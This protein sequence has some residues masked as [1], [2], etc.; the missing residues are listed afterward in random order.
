M[1]GVFTVVLLARDSHVCKSPLDDITDEA[2]PV[3][4]TPAL[5]LTAMKM[6]C[7]DGRRHALGQH[8]AHVFSQGEAYAYHQ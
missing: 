1:K 8:S 7:S 4:G 5:A 2:F 3:S 6:L